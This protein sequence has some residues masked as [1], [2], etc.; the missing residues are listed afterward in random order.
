[1]GKFFFVLRTQAEI[2]IQGHFPS[3]RVHVTTH[4]VS[5]CSKR[6]YKPERQQRDTRG[7]LTRLWHWST[8]TTRRTFIDHEAFDDNIPWAASCQCKLHLHIDFMGFFFWKNNSSTDSTSLMGRI[9]AYLFPILV[10]RRRQ[11]GDLVRHS[12]EELEL[13][14]RSREQQVTSLTAERDRARE[15][16]KEQADL[17]AAVQRE[18]DQ[19][20]DQMKS[21]SSQSKGLGEQLRT[22]NEQLGRAQG[23]TNGLREQLERRDTE[24]QI[25]TNELTQIKAQHLQTVALLDT[26]TS[27]LKSAEAFLSKADTM[28]GA[29]VVR[30]VEGLNAEILQTAAYVADHFEFSQRGDF[31][32][33]ILAA[34]VRLEELL[35]RK[36]VHLLD[37]INHGNDP[38]LIQLACQASMAAYC[39]WMILSWDTEDANYDQFLKHIYTT[40]QQA[41]KS[42]SCSCYSATYYWIEDQAI[43]GRWRA[44]TRT[45]VQSMLH[46][47]GD[48]SS[49]LVPHLID[50]IVDI[51][52]VAGLRATQEYIRAEVSNTFG[53][54]L[55]VIVRLALGLN[56]VIGREVTSCDLEPTSV[57]WETEY[58]PDEMVDVNEEEVS[59]LEHVLCTTD[60]GLQRIVKTGKDAEGPKAY[61]T[62]V[63]LKPKVALESTVESLKDGEV[64]HESPASMEEHELL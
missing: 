38:M 22:L 55:T 24:M 52:L 16:M 62:T 21:I 59:H 44:L 33:E 43:S 42:S 6:L 15:E 40:V 60:L 19:L 37:T 48:V 50:T 54:K 25:V 30:M 39:L 51:L 9:L 34:S 29:D 28:S 35:G 53:N 41:G 8:Y 1:M 7:D 10:D 4:V 47:S 5:G 63:L 2:Y 18:R 17:L 45:H 23:Q 46:G 57:L 20:S 26:R 3:Y 14:I 32:E 58:N 31:T 36:V 56:W 11:D 64:V 27:E 49:I 61:Q 12:Q 13:V